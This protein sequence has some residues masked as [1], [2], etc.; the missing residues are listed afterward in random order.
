[1]LEKLCRFSITSLELKQIL[2]FYN[3][4]YSLIN[5]DE[6]YKYIKQQLL[7]IMIQAAKHN[8]Q[9]TENISA[10]FDLQRPNSGIIIPSIKHWSGSHITYYCWLRL[11]HELEPYLS[12][13]RRQ[14]YSFYSENGLGFEAFFNGNSTSLYLLVNDHKELTYVEIPECDLIDGCWHSLTI[15]YFQQKWTMCH[16]S[17]YIDG[18]LK[19]CIKDFKYPFMLEILSLGSIGSSSQRPSHSK[20]SSLNNT[21]KYK[22]IL[23]NKMAQPLKR[24]FMMTPNQQMNKVNRAQQNVFTTT[25]LN[26]QDTLFGQ[27]T[28]LHGQIAFV[29]LLSDALQE[30]NIKQLHALGADF[31]F[32]H[33]SLFQSSLFSSIIDAQRFN[34]LISDLFATKTI[35]AYH[36]LAC[37][38]ASCVNISGKTQMNG[39]LNYGTC[40]H[41]H[42]YSKSLLSIGSIP[43]LYLLFECFNE[44]EYQMNQT[45]LTVLSDVDSSP[46]ET[47]LDSQCS[48]W[49]IT[50][51]LTTDN[52]LQLNPCATILNLIHCI[53]SSSKYNSLHIE[54]MCRDYN[55][56]ILQKYLNNIPF[57]FIDQEFLIAIQQIIDC[58]KLYKSISMVQTLINSFVQYLLL[59]F[60]LWK[61]AKLNVQLM[62]IE[63][64]T[65][66][67]KDDRIYFRNKFGIQYFLDSIKQHFSSDDDI[68]NKSK[69]IRSGI[70][71]IMNYYVQCD[72]KFDE[73]NSIL[74][75]ISALTTHDICVQEMLNFILMLLLEI[76]TSSELTVTFLCEPNMAGGLYS[77]IVNKDLSITTKE[78][79]FQIMK[80]LLISKHVPLQVKSLLRLENNIGYGGIISSFNSNEL[81]VPIVSEILNLIIMSENTIAVKHVN[82][83]LTLCST[84]SLD[85]RYAA[86]RKLM[87]CFTAHNNTL[88][89]YSKCDGWHETLAHFLIQTRRRS[90]SIMKGD[91]FNKNHQ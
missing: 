67:I 64:L 16:L 39:W 79:I 90:L 78:K 29:W 38:D 83:V 31:Y 8:D 37:K 70:I 58:L 24:L 80:Y 41:L 57:Y 66:I 51:N 15:V 68:E 13:Q 91:R 56:Q 2:L 17:I 88:E 48:D 34:H 75:F 33:S 23:T 53:F 55:V 9:D 22:S 43:A 76:S 73:L 45:S 85:V 26:C 74:S 10:Y 63:Y 4:T 11:N 40:S 3:R 42:S 87:T 5:I 60:N 89:T 65:K 18:C 21:G 54:Q 77:L 71:N 62:H 19:K 44:Q 27:S 6:Q 14:L 86:I 20:L 72:I 49:T 30:K 82:V 61:K 25:D 52:Y 47:L 28:S 59:D 1:M 35:F 7:R 46:S 12:D 50:N 32:S 81:S 36:P 69:K 84:G